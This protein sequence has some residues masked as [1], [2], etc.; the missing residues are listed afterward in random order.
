MGDAMASRNEQRLAQA[1]VSCRT[2]DDVQS[3]LLLAEKVYGPL[4]QRHVGDRANNIGTIRL[5]SDPA[6]GV[7][8]RVVNGMDA[9]LDLGRSLH[10]D[11]PEPTSPVEAANLWYGI[12]NQGMGEMSDA[13]RRSL[14]EKLRITLEESGEDK[15]PTVVWEDEGIGQSPGDFPKT[16]VSLNE[17]NKVGQPW[18]MGTY[19]QGGAVT[20]GF[21]KATVVISRRHHAFRDGN[22]DM[23]GWTIVQEVETDPAK[24][25]LPTYMYVVGAG[26]A[27]LDL[28]PSLF[29]AL[30]HGTIIRGIS[31][32]LQGWH[33]PYTTGLWQL[34]NAAVFEPVLPFL[35]T[36][37]R[38]KEQGTGSRIV[39]GSATRLNTPERARGDI[40]IAHRDSTSLDLGSEFGEVK[41][42]YWVV[43]RPEGSKKVSEAAGSY[44][45]TDSAVS[46]TL[47]GQ[48]QDAE[49]RMWIRNN[50]KLPY[51]YKNMVV[52]INANGLTPIAK[53][54]LFASTRE[55]ATKSELRERIYEQL[56]RVLLEDEELKRLNHEERE[57]LLQRSTTAT[58]EQVRKRLAKYVTTRLK[59]VFQIG[60]GGTQNGGTGTRKKKPGG[61]PKP[62]DTDDS[63]LHS[64]PSRLVIERKSMSVPQGGSTFTWVEIDAKNGYLPKHEDDL[65]VEIA[66]DHGGKLRLL[67]RSELLGGKSRWTFEA[68]PDAPLGG[69]EVSASLVTPNGML[70]D[71][72][73]LEVKKPAEAKPKGK[74]T[75]EATGPRV[76]WI[77]KVDWEEHDD[78]DARNVGYVAEDEEE[79]VIWVNRDYHLLAKALSGNL[80]PEQVATR[81]DRYQFPVACALWLQSHQL[82]D[83]D[84]KPDESYIRSEKERLAEAVLLAS[85][86]DVALALEDNESVR[87]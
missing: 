48:R 56:M 19:G 50:A 6:L 78:M 71:K 17:S 7:V 33:G 37:N 27:V 3:I 59:G 60:K 70:T 2:C 65:T 15:R 5:G 28:D 53:R 63:S 23:V 41:F 16:L 86:V 54:E 31:Y 76:E 66:G 26:S 34:L 11:D 24:R 29:P 68:D 82:K 57:R 39:T 55:R 4:G 69:Y 74:G 84:R 80:T 30:E 47:F 40:E 62:R 49:S 36:G 85:N 73:R 22:A 67:R 77:Y 18:N 25:M 35:I 45:Q 52:Q 14:G 38:K 21:S 1:L 83:T 32:D 79:T 46:M 61:T 44:V 72:T 43:R 20:L 51:L 64:F 81:A 58:N 42:N 87:D 12:P 75:E 8:E 9:L 13:E 10:P